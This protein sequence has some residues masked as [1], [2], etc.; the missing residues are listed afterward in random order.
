MLYTVCGQ[1]AGEDVLLSDATQV[2]DDT[3]VADVLA[4]VSDEDETAYLG[5]LAAMADAF[6]P[7]PDSGWLEQGDLYQHGDG[8][9]MVR[10]SHDRMHY[11][12]EET[13]ALFWTV[14]SSDEWMAGEWV[15]VGTRRTYEGVLYEA[16]QAHTTQS[17]WPP[18]TSPTLWKA[19][20]EGD[21]P[22]PWQQPTGAHDAYQK[23][24]LVTHKEEVWESIIND[25]VWEPG[26]YG[27][28]IKND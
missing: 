14:N 28:V 8:V 25:N 15:N 21:E 12:P 3:G 19:I 9:V 27:W 7:L 18:D 13:P 17:D 16:I 10:Q 22:Q 2:G 20:Q 26:V 6:P 24:D 5:A 23:G 11:A 4:V 1:I